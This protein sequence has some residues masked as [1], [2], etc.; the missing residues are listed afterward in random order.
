MNVLLGSTPVLSTSFISL[1]ELS[2]NNFAKVGLSP[3][4]L[5]FTPQK[6]LYLQKALNCTYFME[7]FLFPIHLI[8]KYVFKNQPHTNNNALR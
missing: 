4:D 8:D 1:D 7:H 6:Q 3:K 2:K 5:I